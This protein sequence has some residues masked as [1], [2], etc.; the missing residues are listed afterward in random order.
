MLFFYFFL[1]LFVVVLIDTLDVARMI[2][3][4]PGAGDDEC[5]INKSGEKAGGNPFEQDDSDDE[6]S[7]SDNEPEETG[8][9]Q[10]YEQGDDDDD[11][12]VSLRRASVDQVMHLL[13]PP[14]SE[15][16]DLQLYNER[17]VRTAKEVAKQMRRAIALCGLPRPP[18]KVKMSF[19]RLTACSSASQTIKVCKVSFEIICFY[20]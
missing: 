3:Q 16:P 19:K 1:F 10:D 6:E 14:V 17:R 15:L 12:S 5:D 2:L 4:R 11:V 18:W 9:E 13:Q 7:E 20:F 8:A